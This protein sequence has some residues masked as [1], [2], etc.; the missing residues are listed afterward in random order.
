MKKTLI[1]LFA[2][3][4]V[5]AAASAASAAVTN[6]TSTGNLTVKA[7]L[8]EGCG[9]NFGNGNESVIDFGSVYDLTNKMEQIGHFSIGCSSLKGQ[10]NVYKAASVSLNQ[11]SVTGSTVENRLLGNGSDTLAFQVYLYGAGNADTIWGD[12]SGTTQV[13]PTP[14]T[15]G[16][17]QTYDYRVRLLPQS[18]TD[19]PAGVYQNTMVATVNYTADDGQTASN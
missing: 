3:A 16:Q 7:T 4:S 12:G 5:A 11:G 9:I 1:A 17:P 18:V 10:T 8:T 6:Q 15:S 13:Y 19:K 14:V 2:T